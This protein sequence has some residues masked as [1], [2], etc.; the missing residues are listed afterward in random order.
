MRL[1]PLTQ[2]PHQPRQP[3][4]EPEHLMIAALIQAPLTLTAVNTIGNPSLLGTET[5]MIVVV[6][7]P[8]IA[9]DVLVTIIVKDRRDTTPRTAMQTA[10]LGDHYI[11]DLHICAWMTLNGL[12][13]SN[14]AS[15]VRQVFSVTSSVKIELLTLFFADISRSFSRF[16]F[17]G[18]IRCII[19][20]LTAMAGA[21]PSTP[22]ASLLYFV[23]FKLT[24]LHCCIYSDLLCHGVPRLDLSI[25]SGFAIDSG[26]ATRSVPHSPTSTSRLASAGP[27]VPRTYALCYGSLPTDVAQFRAAPT[28]TSTTGIIFTFATFV[29]N[30]IANYILPTDTAYSP[31][32]TT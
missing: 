22:H 25:H 7:H 18:P 30:L 2:L 8:P 32:R 14:N 20:L 16:S 1:P 23:N 9:K 28:S 17:L 4:I 6:I 11:Q 26:I 19:S 21:K 31:N 12:F 13:W 10:H 27:N 24:L 3:T 5:P 15:P 29:D